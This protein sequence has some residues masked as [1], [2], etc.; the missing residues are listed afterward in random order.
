MCRASIFSRPCACDCLYLLHIYGV[1]R[2]G[3]CFLVLP[4]TSSIIAH[5]E[6]MEKTAPTTYLFYLLMRIQ[7]VYFSLKSFVYSARA[8]FTSCKRVSWST[9][10]ACTRSLRDLTSLGKH[11]RS[12]KLATQNDIE[13]DDPKEQGGLPK[14]SKY[15]PSHAITKLVKRYK[16]V[17]A[18]THMH[19][20]QC[21]G[22]CV[23]AAST[24]SLR[25]VPERTESSR[26]ASVLSP[27]CVSAQRSFG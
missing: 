4:L 17:K 9:R 1:S 7:I 22:F 13:N 18:R 20:V 14:A 16:L 15:V 27:I 2:D 19:R 23:F 8:L 3:A 5:V 10:E 21:V 26:I 24:T 11:E 6:N 12:Q 25:L